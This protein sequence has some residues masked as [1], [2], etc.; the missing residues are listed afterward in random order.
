MAHGKKAGLRENKNKTSIKDM[1]DEYKT[2]PK[3]L[4][5]PILKKYLAT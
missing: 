3:Q 4:F 2:S 1:A 5:F